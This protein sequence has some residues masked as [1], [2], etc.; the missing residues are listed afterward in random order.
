MTQRAI[1][2]A[3]GRGSRLGSGQDVPKPLRPIASVPLIVRILRTL[4]GEGLREAVVVL[5]H[6]GDEIRRVLEGEPS[7]VMRLRFVDNLEY[8]KKNGVSLLAAREYITGDCLLSMADHL[9]SPEVVRRLCAFDMPASSA[10]LAVDHDIERCF[11]ID[12]ATKV[13]LGWW[14]SGRGRIA[15]IGKD[16]AD[17]DAIDTGVFRIGPALVSELERAYRAT[18]DCSLSDGVAALARKGRMC[19]CGIGDA[20]W[21]DVDTPEAAQRAEAMLHVFGETL[22]DEPSGGARPDPAAI[23]LFAP[24]WVRAAKPYNEDHFALAERQSGIVR[25]MSNESPY[26]P[27]ERVLQAIVEAALDGNHYPARARELRDQLGARAEMSGEH[28]LLGAGSA[29]L[30]DLAIRTFVAPGEEVVI[31]VPT[32]SMYEAR[33]R[34]VGGLPVMVPMSEEGEIDVPALIAA[35]TERTKLIFLCTPNNPTGTRIDESQLRRI[36]RLGLPTVIDEAYCELSSDGA[37]L[38]YLIAEFPNTLVLRTFSKAWGLAGMRV[39]YA[40]AHPEHIRLLARVKVPW[41][42]SSVA[43]AA[44]LAVLD[45]VAEQEGRLSSLR[46]GRRYLERELASLEGVRVMPSE[47]NFVVVDA[48]ATGLSAQHIVD[49]MLSRG[50]F[51]RSLESHRAGGSLVRITVGDAQ[52]NVGCVAAFRDVAARAAIDK[53][54]RPGVLAS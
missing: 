26:R 8:D 14:L 2:L 52:Q 38:A 11:D 12:D 10:A 27:S 18:G 7:I 33:T 31:S 13:K 30:I 51:I 21:I 6:R 42:L 44:A 35:I 17:Y 49:G 4:Q 46:A 9:Y 32:F 20:R 23:E 45:D 15:Q 34:T 53:P 1:V 39:G 22:G 48:S 40:L 41:N 54:S 19:A 29:E 47:A 50:Y 16:L 43:I 24:S 25:L 36:L 28:V 5:G 3:A 37:S